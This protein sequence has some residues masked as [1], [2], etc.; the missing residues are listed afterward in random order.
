[1][2]HYLFTGRHPDIITSIL[3]KDEWESRYRGEHGVVF[4]VKDYIRRLT[5][6]Y[7]DVDALVDMLDDERIILTTLMP[8]L[9]HMKECMLQRSSRKL[10]MRKT[11]S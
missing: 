11:S 8:S 7:S 5:L 9:D 4:P 10:R 3:K 2:L 6:P 1:M